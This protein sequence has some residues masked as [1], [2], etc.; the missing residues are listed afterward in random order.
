MAEALAGFD[1]TAV[2]TQFAK[3]IT[4]KAFR[5][6]GIWKDL[7]VLPH[8]VDTSVFYKRDRTMSRET[9]FERA[10]GVGSVPIK[11][12]VVLIGIVA[13]N[14]VRKDYGLAMAAA[15]ELVRRGVNVGLWLH[16]DGLRKAWDLVGLAKEYGLT[17]RIIASQRGLTDED[18]AICYSACDVT[19]G[20]GSEGWG[21]PLSESLACGVPTIHMT[22]AGGADFVPAS[23]QVNPVGYY[24]QGFFGVRRPVFDPSDWADMT[25]DW[26]APFVNPAVPDYINWDNAWEAWKTWILEGIS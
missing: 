4:E 13:T 1:R 14:T 23:M 26:L 8:G 22:Y 7:A 5:D 6:L 20:I 9:L 17:D 12:D 21:M 10:T 2:Y 19:W 24:H 15:A 18:M 11:D 3:R 16:T 25:E